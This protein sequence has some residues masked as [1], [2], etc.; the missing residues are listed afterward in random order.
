MVAV[1]FQTA[2]AFSVQN[3]NF[4]RLAIGGDSIDGGSPNPN[5]L[6]LNKK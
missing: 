1:F 2:K 4:N 6:K 5:A 3:E